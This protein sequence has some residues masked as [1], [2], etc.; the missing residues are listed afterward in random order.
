MYGTF[1]TI[2]G[3][4]YML[5]IIVFCIFLIEL[6]TGIALVPIFDEF[7]TV[8]YNELVFGI[9]ILVLAINDLRSSWSNPHFKFSGKLL[10]T[11][12]EPAAIIPSIALLNYYYKWNISPL[13]AIYENYLFQFAILLLIID[14]Y[15]IRRTIKK[16]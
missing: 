6:S 5:Y 13:N 2:V 8:F 11:T 7:K 4:F 9:S 15:W 16:Y 10:L 12:C 3:W 14:I 1:N